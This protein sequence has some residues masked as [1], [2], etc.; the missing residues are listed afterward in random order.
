MWK[1]RADL[2]KRYADGEMQRTRD[3]VTSPV[4]SNYVDIAGFELNVLYTDTVA[5]GAILARFAIPGSSPLLLTCLCN[6]DVPSIVTEDQYAFTAW[7]EIQR[8]LP[9]RRS[10]VAHWRVPKT[11]CVST[12]P[13]CRLIRPTSGIF[14][15]YTWQ[16]S[17]V[18]AVRKGKT[19]SLS[20]AR[21]MRAGVLLVLRA[22]HSLR[23]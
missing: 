3:C 12:P 10:C 19:S 11:P 22:A 14:M 5:P 8:S 16:H 4:I 18:H 17:L 20:F 9:N 2:V 23:G 1:K 15:L 6:P 21:R 7:T 13:M